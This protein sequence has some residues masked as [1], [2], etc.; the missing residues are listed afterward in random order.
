MSVLKG[1]DHATN[2]WRPAFGFDECQRDCCPMPVS[3][4][5]TIL[6]LT[7]AL[8][9][10]HATAEDRVDF[11]RD[12]RPI[13]S[14]ACLT[15]H[16][17]DDE[18][19]EAGLRLDH[20]ESVLHE[21]DSGS[22]AIVPG[23]PSASELIARITTDDG[24]LRMPPAESGQSLTPTQIE[25]L[26]RWINEGA[27]YSKHWAYVAP[28]RPTVPTPPSDLAEWA[29]N[30]ID[31]FVLHRMQQH[32]LRPSAPADR[33]AL[34][35]RVS[36]DLTGLPPT[37]DEVDQFVGSQDPDAW[38]HLVD[39]LLQRDSFGEHWARKWLDLGRYADSAG[40]ADDPPRTIWAWRD[41]VI[42]AINS[43]MPFDQFTIEQ[44]A[45]DL[46][47]NATDEQL[48]ATAFHRNTMT[49][50]EGGTIDEE[51][52]NVAIVD[53]VNTTFAV[54]MGT[55]MAC[56]QCHSHKYD[57]ISQDEYFQVFAILN[58]TQDA[59]RRDESP[60]LQV[61]T[62]RQRQRR[63]ELQQQITRLN[64]L[65]DTP[66]PELQ[67]SQQTW[68]S[69]LRA[70]SPW[71]SLSA[72]AVN[73]QSDESSEVHPDGTVL[74]SGTA[75][76]DIYTIDLPLP[77]SLT[78]LAALRIETVPHA[79]L[80]GG[81]AGL[82][83]GNFVV[84]A[85]RAQI[86]PPV[87]HPQQARFIRITNLGADQFLSLAEVEVS[88]RSQ[89][90]AGQGTVRQSSTAFGGAAERAIDGNTSG[91]YNDGSTTHTA[92]EQDPWWELDLGQ[93]QPIDSV[94][95]WNRTDNNLHVRLSNFRI[96]LLNEQR[97]VVWQSTVAEPPNPSQNHA[98]SDA[99][100]IPFAAA[101]AD[102]HQPGFEPADVLTGKTGREDGWAVGGKTSEPHALALAPTS[103]VTVSE[104]AILRVTIE[105]NSP[106]KEHL[107]GHF[108]VSVTAD[109][110]AVRRSQLPPDLQ[111]VLDQPAAER[112]SDDAARFAAHYRR[113]VAPE[114]QDQ[115]DHLATAEQELAAVTPVTSVPVMKE[116]TENRRETLFQYRG[117]WQ[118]T[119]HKVT[120]GVPAVFHPLE[121]SRTPDRL[122]LAEW[123]VD[124][125]NPLTAR[126][127]AN[128]WWEVLF[129]RGL[130]S[131]SED[132]GSQGELPTHPLLLD[133]LAADLIQSGWDRKAALKQIVMSATYRQNARVTP[134]A[135]RRDPDNRWLARGP[136]VRLSAEMVR[137]QA[138]FVSGLLSPKMY[139][140]PV[141]PP[142]PSQGLRAA[143]GSSTDWKTSTGED[144]YR[145]AIYTSWRRSNPYP[146]MTTFDA[147]N[148]E[149]CTLRR[150][151][152]NTPLQSLV[153]L[154]DPVY[155]EAAQSLARH[156][157]QHSEDEEQQ[158][159]WAFR[160]C[161]LRAPSPDELIALRALYHE[162][163]QQLAE[164]EEQAMKLA[165]QPL[166]PLPDGL[167]IQ[168][169]AAMTVVGN[170]L[171]NLD[172]MFLK[173]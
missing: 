120:E 171:L 170:V 60:L 102:Y 49:N 59:D 14:G 1:A 131:T 34:I 29:H 76:Q 108:R 141:R 142:Q 151:S 36:L 154:N 79:S 30:D 33:P 39:D 41:W 126:V 47:P 13:L 37:V 100:V 55:T 103:P 101:W 112:S 143:F 58:N 44:L 50:S 147:P 54:W 53:R 64:Q 31:R 156:A 5:A 122:A 48:I 148:R 135:A 15:C 86:V 106:H 23:D 17:P 165:T 4:F 140:P 161:L 3:R 46:L 172:E 81:G 117:S 24:D 77:E 133:W 89:N 72:A 20:R 144:R 42:R 93:Q 123:L 125:A 136:R 152:T 26:T 56:A 130:V 115:R 105:H 74:I 91:E 96:D 83:N 32:N 82:A 61:Y 40:Y 45:G 119:G 90:I 160:R 116:L 124:G 167:E 114:L 129:G 67:R 75:S 139:G 92:K 149:V 169:A 157:L 22:V 166:G 132:F 121:S 38:E 62:T 25:I 2:R 146:S 78:E 97:E 99:Q 168:D 6:A 150:N 19:R 164:Q 12:V 155:I 71:T 9:T 128:R 163:R 65:I 111:T 109:D 104:P 87:S 98:I 63:Q 51:F 35:R 94:Q 107:L 88:S 52:R 137:D 158:L 66:T 138:L 159:T 18:T 173:R 43:N 127:L 118:N 69:E 28:Q 73:R 10:G 27:E 162:S 145:R 153:T 70:P 11:N 68:E 80:P 110:R 84:T 95:L 21:L 85:V 134:E 57:P 8:T 113:Q 16:G 7:V